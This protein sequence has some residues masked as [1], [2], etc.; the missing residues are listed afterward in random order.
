MASRLIGTTTTDSEGFFSFNGS[1]S[2]MI[3]PGF[4]S[5]VI[6]TQKQGYVGVQ[7]VSFPWSINITDDVNLSISSPVPAEQPMLGVGVN[8]TVTGNMAWANL[9]LTDPAMLDTLQVLLNYTTIEDGDVNLISDVGSGGYFEFTVPI[10]ENEPLG[11]INAS[12]AFL[13]WHQTDLNN[14]SNPEYHLRPNAIDFNFNITPSPNLTISLEGSDA[15]NS[16]LD[17]NQLVFING[18]AVSRGPSPE[19]LNGS[20]TF[21]MRRAGTN[22]PYTDL[23]T[24]QLNSSNWTTTPGQFSIE[25]NFNESSVPIPAGLVEVKFIYSAEELFA[26]DEESFLSTFGI[27]SYVEFEYQLI[28]TERGTEALVGVQLSD[29]TGTSVADFPGLY[30]VDFN[31]TE[32]FNI[33]DP[34]S[35]SFNV[36]WVPNSNTFAGDYL[37]QLNYTGSTWLRPAS[38]LDTIRIQG[39]ANVTVTL[40]SEWTDRGTVLSLIHI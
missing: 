13:G 21:Q 36:V 23:A 1:P 27:R 24:W 16:I 29:H 33:T 5:L 32:V 39:K 6:L 7:S 38:V 40:G 3:K 19:P 4:G 2:E 8:S 20:L 35:G 22:G 37:W 15:N 31:G 25:W 11:L 26:T 9:P 28:P 10:S 14:A 34:E 18:T 30:S 17:I 12:L